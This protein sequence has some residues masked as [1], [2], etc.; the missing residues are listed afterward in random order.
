MLHISPRTKVKKL[1]FISSLVIGWLIECNVPEYFDSSL[2]VGF[3][4][5]AALVLAD[6]VL[7][8]YFV[9]CCV[10]SLCG[11]P[12]FVSSVVC[13]LLHALIR[14]E[15]A[16]RLA[17]LS[18]DSL[19]ILSRFLSCIMFTFSVRDDGFDAMRSACLIMSL[20]MGGRMNSCVCWC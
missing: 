19:G 8:V 5:C 6:G 10:Y 12:I 20:G 4:V 14:L 2:F 9:G 7:A 17:L 3:V 16:E 1:K 18:F 11:I 15:R 13:L